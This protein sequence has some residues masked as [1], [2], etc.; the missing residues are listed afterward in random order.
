MKV[1]KEEV[2][3][4]IVALDNFLKLDNDAEIKR[5]NAKAEWLAEQL[6]G[7]RGLKA[8]P[9]INT[10]GYTDVVLSWDRDIIPLTTQQI[11]ER[12]MQGEPRITWDITLRTRLLR[13]GEEVLVAKRLRRFFEKEA[14]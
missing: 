7:I 8:E 6:Q 11:K 2:I 12:L 1:G 5:W 4:L 13:E 10:M 14:S 3:G 9:T